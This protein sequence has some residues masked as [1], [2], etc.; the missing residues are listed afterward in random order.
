MDA[1]QATA[2]FIGGLAVGMQLSNLIWAIFN[3]R[4]K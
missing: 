2:I 3:N 1:L 4:R